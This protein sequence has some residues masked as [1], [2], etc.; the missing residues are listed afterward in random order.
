LAVWVKDGFVAKVVFFVAKVGFFGV[1]FLLLAFTMMK[2]NLAKTLSMVKKILCLIAWAVLC[3]VSNAVLAD[4][5]RFKIEL[6][7]FS[8]NTS[9]RE[10]FQPEVNPVQWP[11]VVAELADFSAAEKELGGFYASLLSGIGYQSLTHV[12][13]VQNIDSDT[14]GTPVKIKD[15]NNL[16]NGWISLRRGQS[17]QLTADFEFTP[18]AV[19]D[20]STPAP[21]SAF[22]LKE[23]RG[24][25]F[26]EIHYFDHPKF[27]VIA[28]VSPL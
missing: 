16:L 6:I 2:F 12:A 9:S 8:Q 17:L 3:I 19:S 11:S 22:R 24:I 10:V 5:A 21:A 14:E 15:A 28:K 25:K 1:K 18:A 26:N 27:G 4:S 7:V 23:S 13:W 20:F